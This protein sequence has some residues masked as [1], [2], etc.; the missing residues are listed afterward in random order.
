M[1]SASLEVTAAAIWKNLLLIVNILLKLSAIVVQNAIEVGIEV[2]P[3][4]S[5]YLL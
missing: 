1:G 5:R 2:L 3:A 4:R